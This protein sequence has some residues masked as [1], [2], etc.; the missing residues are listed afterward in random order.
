M[1]LQ[2]GIIG[3]KNHAL[4]LIKLISQNKYCELRFIYHPN[5]KINHA[6]ATNSLQD[7][8]QCD[9]VIIASP[10]H[11]HFDYTMNL[12]NNFKGY[13]FCEKPP[14]CHLADLEALFKIPVLDKKRIYFNYNFRFGLL[15]SVISDSYYQEKLGN[16]YSIKIL[17][18]HGLAFKE[19]YINSWRADGKHNLH[20][21]TETVAIHY[22][23]LLRF[24]YG[25]INRYFYSPSIVANTGT[26]YDTVHMSLIFDKITAFIFASYACPFI[27]EV[28][29]IGTEGILKMC[30]GQLNLYHPRDIFDDNGFF[31]EPP[32]VQKHMINKQR[33]YDNSLEKS[34]DFFICHVREGRE[35]EVG[36]FEASLASN[37][38]LLEVQ[39][40][41]MKN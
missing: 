32:L 38:F 41:A 21:I 12:L 11:T 22:V 9:A 8:Y 14:V 10:S 28:S 5:K 13:I 35:I 34:L 24:K 15:S 20:A 4:R 26:A 25:Q 18:G 3:Y 40:S 31:K 2:V 16:V 23:D 29:I 7:L 1:M 39:G 36:F 30:E 27:D 37:R 33:E 6:L 19:D 17:T